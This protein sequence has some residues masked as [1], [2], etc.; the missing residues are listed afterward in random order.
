MNLISYFRQFEKVWSRSVEER[1][2]IADRL[3][4][5]SYIFLYLISLRVYQEDGDANE[6]NHLCEEASIPIEQLIAKYNNSTDDDS[7]P[8]KP[9]NP[10][11]AGLKKVRPA[12]I[13]LRF[14]QYDPGL[15]WEID[16]WKVLTEE[17][18]N[19]P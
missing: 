5:K 13:F 1:T 17:C 3:I 7:E 11:L 12:Y 16:E 18:Y 15:K 2:L 8:S 19:S 10:L 6:I 14:H 9:V 4:K